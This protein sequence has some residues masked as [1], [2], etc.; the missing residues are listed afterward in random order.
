M[1]GAGM[2]KT[3]FKTSFGVL[4]FLGI[5][6]AM[7]QRILD[8]IALEF[9]VNKVLMGTLVMAHF[10]GF[11][12]GPLIAGELSDRY[13][14]KRVIIF[15]FLSFCV[16]LILILLSEAFEF[17]FIGLFFAGIGFGILE[18]TI[19]ALITDMKQN[20]VNK[21]MN[22]SQMFLAIGTV[23]GP[24]LAMLVVS[25]SGRWKPLFM[26]S[27][28]ISLLFMF[29]FIKTDYPDYKVTETLQGTITK[30]LLKNKHFLILCISMIM[31]VGVE[32]GL[33]FWITTYIKQHSIP[34]Y[35]PTVAL[36]LFWASMIPG[37]YLA[38]RFKMRLNA[39]IA[40]GS[41]MSGVFLIAGLLSNNYLLTILFF[42]LIGFGLSGIFPIIMAIVKMKFQKYA[43]TAFGLIMSCC[44]IGGV[45][46]PLIMGYIGEFFSLKIA[47]SF[48]L[49]PLLI[50]IIIH[51]FII[52]DN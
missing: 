11:F 51:T 38:S 49:I 5:Y 16:G 15:A 47:L 46:V 28:L 7:L 35:Y 3:L 39:L 40:M 26:I 14:R 31:Y 25:L 9:S 4:F 43:G 42:F 52:K 10:L 32:E 33:A 27:F 44:A 34:D 20:D 36:S 29:I 50:I 23:V 24:F 6:L 17:V 30:K 19:S 41:G 2:N 22:I 13:G 48:C 18:G 1:Y 37:R 12:L 45:T 21:T 8:E